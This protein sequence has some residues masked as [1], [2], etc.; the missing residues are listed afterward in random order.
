VELGTYTVGNKFT[1]FGY[2]TG[3][4]G[5]F[6]GLADGAEF[7]DDLANKWQIDYNDT[8][9]GLNGGIGTSF[10]TITSVPEPGAAILGSLGVIFL[11]RRRR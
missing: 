8:T 2:T 3:I 7:N 9:A 10:V 11:L 6:D 4:T 1:L 5:T